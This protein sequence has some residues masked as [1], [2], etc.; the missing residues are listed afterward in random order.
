MLKPIDDSGK[1]LTI[2]PYASP[3]RP[4]TAGSELRPLTSFAKRSLPIDNSRPPTANSDRPNTSSTR[5]SAVWNKS[6]GVLDKI[7][8]SVPLDLQDEVSQIIYLMKTKAESLQ[9]MLDIKTVEVQ[10]L[11]DELSKSSG[12]VYNLAQ[13]CDVYRSR[14]K[15]LE[16]DHDHLH[17]KLLNKQKYAIKC[18]RAMSRLYSTNRLLIDSLEA[19]QVSAGHGSNSTIA[20]TRSENPPS[21]SRMASSGDLSSDD[22]KHQQKSLIHKPDNLKG[23]NT[24]NDSKLRE[25]LLRIARE[26]YKSVKKGEILEKEVEDMRRRVRAAEQAT[27]MLQLELDEVRSKDEGGG[28]KTMEQRL[29]GK[30]PKVRS[31]T[32]FDERLKVLRNAL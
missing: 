1:Q 20:H 6:R 5:I 28:A 8:R 26:H 12:E 22:V 7:I 3:S 4:G 10:A 11:Q 23:S 14:I 9:H 32:K 2:N 18:Q 25:A 29:A 16:S 21:F 13:N 27:R 31:L 30:T 19:L 17:E 24:E 15:S